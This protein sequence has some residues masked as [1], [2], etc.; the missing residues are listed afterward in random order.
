[1]RKPGD[2]LIVY[3]YWALPA[4]R[5]YCRGGD[6]GLLARPSTVAKVLEPVGHDGRVWIMA[7]ADDATAGAI[8]DAYRDAATNWSS[9]DRFTA[10]R[11]L[12]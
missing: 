1:M 4:F 11:C 2:G 6:V 3:P 9:A 7:R 10:C 8:A 5:Y 12:R